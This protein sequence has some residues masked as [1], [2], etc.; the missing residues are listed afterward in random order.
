MSNFT[1]DG[2]SAKA[3]GL[4]VSGDNV[5]NGAQRLYDEYQIPGRNGIVYI[6]TGSYANVPVSYTVR[7]KPSVSLD[8]SMK[9]IRDW[10]LFPD[11]Y[12]KLT[13][14]YQPNIY[15]MAR[16]VGDVDAT[17]GILCRYGEA[18]LTFD[19]KPQR[20]FT[21][22]DNWRTIQNAPAYEFTNDSLQEARPLF[23]IEFY[24]NDNV[25]VECADGAG[26]GATQLWEIEVDI[27][28]LPA[29]TGTLFYD[30]ELGLAYWGNGDYATDAVTVTGDVKIP[31][32]DTVYIRKS[33]GHNT[34]KMQR[35]DWTL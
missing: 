12:C 20:Y 35:R 7:I 26:A 4:I 15:R 22:A 5:F 19:C 31:A 21:G 32:L 28:L 8:S 11:G 14:T 10:L 30:A 34:V 9:R 25:I 2:V 29:G 24:E 33:A 23:K 16:F 17:I 3:L 1:F 27:T 6:S 18:T 13:D